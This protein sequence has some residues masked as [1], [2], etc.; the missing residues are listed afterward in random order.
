M[1]GDN[2]QQAGNVKDEAMLAQRDAASFPAAG[3][4]YFAAMDGGETL[5][6][7]QVK[8]RNMSIVWTGGDDR[9]WDTFVRTA[10]ARSTC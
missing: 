3:E 6:P 7:D 9:L 5:T 8:G 2:T 10:T 4:D 1:L